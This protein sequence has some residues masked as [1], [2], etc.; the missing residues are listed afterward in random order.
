MAGRRALDTRTGDPDPQLRGG[1]RRVAGRDGTPR[2]RAPARFVAVGPLGPLDPDLR[3]R[4]DRTGWPVSSARCRPRQIADATPLGTRVGGLAA[5]RAARRLASGGPL[6]N[7]PARP[8]I[9]RRRA[10]ERR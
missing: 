6:R 7:G 9:R 10:L 1:G 5:A 8:T 3:S 2:L 4:P